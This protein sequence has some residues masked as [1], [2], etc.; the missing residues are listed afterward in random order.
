MWNSF[1]PSLERESKSNFV[2]Q[3]TPTSSTRPAIEKWGKCLWFAVDLGFSHHSWTVLKRTVLYL[4]I[5]LLGEHC[6]TGAS[7]FEAHPDYFHIFHEAKIVGDHTK[8]REKTSNYGF[9]LMILFSVNLTW[10]KSPGTD[11]HESKR[12]PKTPPFWSSWCHTWPKDR[13]RIPSSF[14]FRTAGWGPCPP[15]HQIG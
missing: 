9:D 4:K 12:D 13:K 14:H 5:W 6:Q 7:E 3:K 11:G 2:A 1:L 15:C 10:R 8:N